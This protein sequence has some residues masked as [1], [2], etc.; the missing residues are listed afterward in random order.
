MIQDVQSSGKSWKAHFFL[1]GN[2]DDTLLV[3]PAAYFGLGE[4]GAWCILLCFFKSQKS[5]NVLFMTCQDWLSR[6]HLFVPQ[7]MWF[8][9]SKLLSNPKLHSVTIL[10]WTIRLHATTAKDSLYLDGRGTLIYCILCLYH[11]YGHMLTAIK[12]QSIFIFRICVEL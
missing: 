4:F 8:C 10:I 6:W 12:K 2:W 5:G 11:M 3:Y 9:S 7:R 1:Q